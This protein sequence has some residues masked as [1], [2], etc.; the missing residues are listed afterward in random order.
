[1]QVDCKITTAP[2]LY[3]RPM[4]ERSIDTIIAQALDAID[5]AT[6]GI[7]PAI[8]PSTTFARGSDYELLG[9]HVYGRYSSPTADQA[10][11]ILAQ[12]DAGADAYL[13]ASGMA[14]MTAFFATVERGAHVVALQV[15]YH[16]AQ[17][18]L[19]HLDARGDIRLAL[20]DSADPA[21]LGASIMPDTAVVWIETPVNPTWDVVDIAAAADAAHAVGAKLVVDSTIAPPVTTRPLRPRCRLCF[22]L[23]H[24][25]PQRP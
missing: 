4:A 13:F 22:S 11:A 17:D 23:G 25:V 16:G 20:C 19:R 15:M 3:T 18:W 12:L 10:A 24:E 7:V 9:D 1:M 5:P 14:A 2:H 21:E 6:G 8:Q